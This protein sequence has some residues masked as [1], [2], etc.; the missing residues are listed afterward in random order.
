MEEDEIPTSLRQRVYFLARDGMAITLYAILQENR[1]II[2]QLLNEVSFTLK[3]NCPNWSRCV[4]R[5]MFDCRSA[6]Q[7]LHNRY[8]KIVSRYLEKKTV[9]SPIAFKNVPTYF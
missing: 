1:K 6:S 9:T 5:Y 7:I 8:Y 4:T 3:Y 2:P